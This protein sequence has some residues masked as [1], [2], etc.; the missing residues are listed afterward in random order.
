MRA[1][2]VVLALGLLATTAGAQGAKP[3]KKCPQDSV[4]SGAVCMDKYEASAWRVPDP[5][6]ANKRLVRKIRKGKATLADLTKGGAIQLGIASFDYAPCMTNG[7]NCTD[8]F[9][10]SLPAVN[11]SSI[12]MWFMAQAACKNS[13]KRLPSNAEWEAAVAGTP[14]PGPDNGTTDCTTSGTPTL[15]G[16]RSACVSAAGA[17]DMVGNKYEFVADWLVQGTG[18][19]TWSATV[20]P[21]GDEQGLA[22]VVSAGEPAT[23]LR[24]GAR[25]SG[26]TA[27]PV[28]LL[29]VALSVGDFNIG[30]R[31]AR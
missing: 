1:L 6:G 7:Y 8:I 29:D 19:G 26:S 25:F 27:G 3:L 4:V 22:G 9:A 23:L 12:L 10:V 18:G 16:A 28:A 11:P 2:T 13:A 14:D 5:T 21:T 15:T 24:G 31:C 30:F 17:F 20:S